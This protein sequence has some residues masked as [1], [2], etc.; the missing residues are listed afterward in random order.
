MQRWATR[1]RPGAPSESLR[2]DYSHG[3]GEQDLSSANGKLSI[4]PRAQGR[5]GA[6]AGRAVEMG[7]GVGVERGSKSGGDPARQGLKRADGAP[8][9]GILATRSSRAVSASHRRCSEAASARRSDR[10]SRLLGFTSFLAAGATSAKARFSRTNQMK[11]FE[12]RTNYSN[13]LSYCDIRLH[14]R[15]SQIC[16]C[17]CVRP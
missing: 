10:Q 15:L 14:R 3:R 6:R 7:R 11:A 9:G 4:F 8:G 2:C 13:G 12:L 5:T 1:P 16:R 17:N